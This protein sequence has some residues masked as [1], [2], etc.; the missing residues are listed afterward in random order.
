MPDPTTQPTK[1]TT[2]LSA[3]Q[4]L[5]GIGRAPGGRRG[6][7]A[8]RMWVLIG[9]GAVALGLLFG[10]GMFGGSAGPSYKT[11]AVKRGGLT[12]TVTATGSVQPRNQVEVSSELSGTVRK[13]LVDFNSSVAQDQVLAELDVEKLS[14]TL[15][16]SRAKLL[17]AKAQVT[18]AEATVKET[19][20]EYHRKKSLQDRNFSSEQVLDSAFAAYQRA[21]ASLANAKAQVTVAEADLKLNEVNL[22]KSVIRSPINGVVLKRSVDPGQTVAAT[23]QAPVMFTIAEDLRQMELRVDVDEADVGKLKQGQGATFTVDAY[24]ERRFPAK[25]RLIRFGSETV[26]NVVTYKAILDIDN[27]ELLLRPG[28]TATAEIVIE[29]VEDG[30][31]VPNQAL[32]WQP[33]ALTAPNVSF[34]R[35]LMPGPPLR[36]PPSKADDEGPNRTVYMLKAGEPVAA[37]VVVGASDGRASVVTSG[38]A[39]GDEVVLDTATTTK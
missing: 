8:W 9:A 7:P 23:L 13:V 29:R 3:E 11:Q 1:P 4:V 6:R 21:Q 39:E 2:G 16:N 33:A 31:I 38:L 20:Q 15:E 17:A 22:T 5:A 10:P 24:S 28:M 36:R 26:Q 34:L 25:I 30:L 37:K 19:E 32:R 12:V 18:M 14:A 35:R 27:S